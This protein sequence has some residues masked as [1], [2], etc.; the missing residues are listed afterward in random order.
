Q[1]NVT[2]DLWQYTSKG[3]LSGISGNVDLSKVVDSSTVNSWLKTTSADVAKPTYFTSLPSDKQVT[4]SKNIYEYQDVNF[5][6]R[7]S[8]I[9]AGKSLS[10]KSITRSNG[11]A[12]RFQLTNGNY[13]TANKAYVTD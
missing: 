10:V 3:R 11:G 7:V 13:I 6:S 9:T 1:P 5:K 4:T 2:T 12:Y 8:K